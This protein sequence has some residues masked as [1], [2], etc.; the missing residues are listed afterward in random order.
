MNG[1]VG[2]SVF[3]KCAEGYASCRHLADFGSEIID[4]RCR[5]VMELHDHL[6]RAETDLPIAGCRGSWTGLLLAIFIFFDKFSTD[7]SKNL[8]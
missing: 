7:R 6:S 8:S 2:S 5:V 1:H 4:S 3:A